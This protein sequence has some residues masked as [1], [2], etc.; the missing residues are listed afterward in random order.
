MIVENM[1]DK[2]KMILAVLAFISAI[3]IGFIAL[4]MPPKGVIDSS[5][6]WF[7]SQLLVF[8]ATMLGLNLTLGKAST[9]KQ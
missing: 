4:F 3:V 1:S 7:T 2:I 8:V 9:T 5:V 6:L